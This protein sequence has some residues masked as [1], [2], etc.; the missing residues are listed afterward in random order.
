MISCASVMYR[1][2]ECYDYYHSCVPTY[3]LVSMACPSVVRGRIIII[4]P[5]SCLVTVL[6]ALLVCMHAMSPPSEYVFH[7]TACKR[8]VPIISSCMRQ[9]LL[10]K[11]MSVI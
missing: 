1:C 8:G 10:M 3:L 4:I 9:L 6:L 2:I 7:I 5:A 11:S